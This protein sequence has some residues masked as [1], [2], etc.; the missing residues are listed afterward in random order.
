LVEQI[1]TP[2]SIVFRANH[3]SNAYLL[4]GTLPEDKEKIL[5]K[6]SK[7]QVNPELSRP[8]YLRRF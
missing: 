4:G 3:A 7:L 8:K 1:D 6:I 5:D 2:K